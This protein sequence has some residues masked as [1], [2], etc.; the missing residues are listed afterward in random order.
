MILDT[1]THPPLPLASRDVKYSF[2]PYPISTRQTLHTSLRGPPPAAS[3]SAGGSVAN[4]SSSNSSSRASLA[5]PGPSTAQLRAE[6]RALK[7]AQWRAVGGRRPAGLGLGREAEELSEEEE[8][9]E[10]EKVS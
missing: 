5:G 10:D 8:A 2:Y 7:R 4:R 1:A 9:L 6:A 3:S